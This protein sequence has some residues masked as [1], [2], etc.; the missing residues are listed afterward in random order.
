[1]LKS[2]TEILAA[3]ILNKSTIKQI[4]SGRTTRYSPYIILTLDSLKQKRYIVKSKTKGFQ[5]TD[6][7]LKALAEFYPAHPVSNKAIYF[8]LLSKQ[9]SETSKAIK[10]IENLGSEYNTKIGSMNV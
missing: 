8:K 7:G 6:K 10:M 4:A 3:I 2:E 5:I 9:A 1:M